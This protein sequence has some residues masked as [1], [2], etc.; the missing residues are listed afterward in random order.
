VEKQENLP[1]FNLIELEKRVFHEKNGDIFIGGEKIKA[2]IRSI[3]KDQAKYIETSQLWEILS[4]TVINESV[5]LAFES[6]NWDNVQYA[7]ALKYWNTVIKKAV[8]SL[9]K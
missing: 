4:S 1:K 8:S 5:R 6:Q 9:A 2:D 3:L 7:K